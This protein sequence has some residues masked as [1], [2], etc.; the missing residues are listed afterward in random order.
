[1]SSKCNFFTM[2]ETQ[3]MVK[4][5]AN[6]FEGKGLEVL[7]ANCEGYPDPTKIQGVVPDIVGWDA[8][9]ELY[10]LAIIANSKT[11]PSDKTKEKMTVLSNMMMGVGS[12]EGKRLPFY[13]GIP[14]GDSNDAEKELAVNSAPSQENIHKVL[15]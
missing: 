1:M 8:K 2:T 11:I 10:H 12:S 15:V 3:M 6:K 9:Q 7:Y 13:V 4:N 14:K 5:L